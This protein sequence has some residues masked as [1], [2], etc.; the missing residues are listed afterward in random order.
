M[1][2]LSLTFEQCRYFRTHTTNY[3]WGTCTIFSLHGCTD[4]AWNIA[5]YF[6]F[7]F[8]LWICTPL[9]IKCNLVNFFSYPGCAEDLQRKD[10]WNN[11][12]E[13]I[14]R[15]LFV[16][17]GARGPSSRPARTGCVTLTEFLDLHSKQVTKGPNETLTPCKSR[18]HRPLGRLNVYYTSTP[19]SVENLIYWWVG[20]HHLWPLPLENIG[21]VC[22]FIDRMFVVEDLLFECRN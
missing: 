17:G 15:T 22:I 3:W 10:E 19:L 12:R 6:V 7:N 8:S 2:S 4:V 13:I 14:Y 21:L 9:Y 18:L 16:H 5:A 20:C 11:L 1:K